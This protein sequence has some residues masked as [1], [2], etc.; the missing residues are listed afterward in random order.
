MKTF[1]ER[2]AFQNMTER[3]STLNEHF[4]ADWSPPNSLYAAFAI[5][6]VLT[7]E[8]TISLLEKLFVGY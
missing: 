2:F 4:P 1:P 3:Q 7:T 6:I 5:L 8:I